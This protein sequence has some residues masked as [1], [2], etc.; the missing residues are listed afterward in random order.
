MASASDSIKLQGEV[1]LPVSVPKIH[2]LVQQLEIHATLRLEAI[3]LVEPQAEDAPGAPCFQVVCLLVDCL[4]T[5]NK[6]FYYSSKLKN[7]GGGGGVVLVQLT[8]WVSSRR[9][10]STTSVL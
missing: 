1:V 6:R 2:I 5:K 9:S 10:S 7:W 4:Y 8:K 3:L